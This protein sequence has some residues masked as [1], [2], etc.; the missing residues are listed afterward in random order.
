MA[1][2]SVKWT[3]FTVHK[4]HDVDRDKPYLWVFG[5]VIDANTIPEDGPEF[6]IRRRSDSDNLGGK[7]GKGDSTTVS[8]S[9]DIS[10]KV[11]P[12]P[13][14]NLATAGVVVVA[15]ENA[16]T[17]D[18][19]IADAYDA[20][21][22]EIEAFVTERVQK[23]DLEPSAADMAD[24]Q[25]DVEATVRDTIR[26]GWSVF[27]LVPDHVI[28]TKYALFNLDGPFEDCLDFRFVK[29]ST[30][31]SLRADLAYTVDAGTTRPSGPPPGPNDVPVKYQEPKPTT[32]K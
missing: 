9:L 5:I 3:D 4:K 10:Q 14:V 6:V 1:Q 25:A 22:D 31:Y 19:V 13:L 8:S 27:Q 30:D 18:R 24:L 23:L 21:A 15:W 26:A 17:R 12:V 20:A 2:F 28:G 32:L 11:T 16:M 7:F 29:G